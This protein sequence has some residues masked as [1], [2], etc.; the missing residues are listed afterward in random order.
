MH[1]S[2]AQHVENI[3]IL[4]NNVVCRLKVIGVKVCKREI[5]YCDDVSM[6]YHWN[7][8][9]MSARLPQKVQWGEILTQGWKCR[10]NSVL[11]RY[12][13]KNVSAKEEKARDNARFLGALRNSKW[14]RGIKASKAKRTRSARCVVCSLNTLA[15]L[16]SCFLLHLRGLGGSVVWDFN[17]SM[18][19]LLFFRQV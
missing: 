6:D 19:Q 9:R 13:K 8:L 18:P 15:S 1:R 4:K 14:F 7:C 3:L 12:V 17:F 5:V 11:C 2:C 10:R 16:G